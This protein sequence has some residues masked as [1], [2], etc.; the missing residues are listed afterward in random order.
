MDASSWDIQQN[1]ISLDGEWAVVHNEFLDYQEIV[2]RYNMNEPLNFVHFP[3]A[4]QT[5]FT[6]TCFL[7]LTLPFEARAETL[8]IRTTILNAAYAM[9]V[10]DSFLFSSGTIS[11]DRNKVTP[12]HDI[13]IGR[14]DAED[15]VYVIFHIASYPFS[16]GPMFT[17]VMLGNASLV[18]S[19]SRRVDMFN[20]LLIGCLLFTC[21]HHLL[22]FL[23]RRKE[24]GSLIFTVV[25]SILIL[26]ITLTEAYLYR[27]NVS[28]F[29]LFAKIENITKHLT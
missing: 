14:F 10:N 27:S 23:V 3:G 16:N 19:I 25:V 21:V 12:E 7:K 2:T 11:L 18:N 29:F 28:L 24:L 4:L 13:K 5:Q 17:P 1:R 20:A 26:R 22:I 9:F 15:E 8:A 6:G